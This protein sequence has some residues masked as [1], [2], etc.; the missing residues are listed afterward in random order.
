MD[1]PERERAVMLA[2]PGDAEV[3]R[4]ASV[5]PATITSQRPMAMSRPALAML[6]VPGRAGRDRRLA[7][8]AQPVPHGNVR[9][10]AGCT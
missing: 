7:R 8:T 1:T 2:K 10:R 3:D 4:G 6:W 5:P 9:R